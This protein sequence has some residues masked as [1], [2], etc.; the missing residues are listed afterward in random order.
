M[1]SA[2]AR[3]KAI[4]RLA[5]P[6]DEE[7]IKRDYEALGSIEKAATLNSCSSFLTGAIIHGRRRLDPLTIKTI[8]PISQNK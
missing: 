2:R 6:V 4:S 7:K 5:K 8:S 3:E 1:A